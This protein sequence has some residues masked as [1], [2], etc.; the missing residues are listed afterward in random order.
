MNGVYDFRLVALSILVSILAAYAALDLANSVTAARGRVR[1][2]WL[3]GGALAMGTGIWGFHLVGTLAV[4]TPEVPA[5]HNLFL[6]SLSL[7][8]AILASALA[9]FAVSRDAVSR[10]GLA[11]AALMLGLAV[12]GMHYLIV[13]SMRTPVRIHRDPALQAVSAA[14][15]LLAAGLT[16]WLANRFRRER[17]SEG[18]WQR[19]GG[20]L[21]IGAALAGAHYTG[22]AALRH[23]PFAS[24]IGIREEEVFANAGLAFAA[25]GGTLLILV[26]ALAGSSVGRELARRKDL[27]EDNLRLFREANSELERRTRAEL[28]QRESE[29]RFRL[30]VT[31]V[32]DYAIF[33]LNP[34]GRV[35]SWNEGAERINGYSREEILGQHF[36][37]F[38]TE[39][40]RER[41]HPAEELR[42]AEREG[43]YQE[44]GW[45]IRK[46]GSLYW[47][48]VVITALRDDTGTLVGFAKVTRDL[49]ERKRSEEERERL[50]QRERAARVE[51]E[52]A[53]RAKADFLAAMG[54]ELRTPLNHIIG[55]ADLLLAGT[56]HPLPEPVSRSVEKITTSARHLL[57]LIEE[58]FTFTRLEAGEETLDRAEVD[59]ATILRE[60][61]SAAEPRAREKGLALRLRI[62]EIGSRVETDPGLVRTIVE[63]LLENAVAFTPHGQIE[64]SLTKGREEALIRVRDTG[65]GIAAGDQERI[66]DPF[67]QLDG[68]TTRTVGGTGMGL[69]LA[70]R[71]ARRLGGDITV[72]SSSGTGSTFTVHLPARF[73]APPAADDHN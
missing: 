23:A 16:M 45:R 54:H 27:A 26:L 1:A 48:H 43:V 15:A 61:A 4:A 5:T 2:G 46:D 63:N 69:A 56:T 70:R 53:S 58:I 57:H 72:Q 17:R 66:F 64:L 55:Y 40:D 32:R 52:E 13:W 11:G 59:L 18:R 20:G 50:L 36:S 7:G 21:L 25:A 65:I 6:L 28:A 33:M 14:L 35:V 41:G 49:S 73:R 31:S 68:G 22:M 51:A 24:T 60:A 47:A 19:L 67:F 62:P 3:W 38:Y 8:V 10:R 42:I 37:T 30:L 34:Q 12:G 71:S 29:E 9:L 39:E 44:E